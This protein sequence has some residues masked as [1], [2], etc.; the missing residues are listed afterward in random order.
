MARGSKTV[1]DEQTKAI[2]IGENT[3]SKSKWLRNNA[4]RSR[5]MARTALSA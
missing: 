3:G 1:N 2:A 5:C 4:V